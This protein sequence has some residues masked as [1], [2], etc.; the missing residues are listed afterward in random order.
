MRSASSG[1]GG[2]SWTVPAE[3][4]T[5][6]AV[7]VVVVVIVSWGSGQS[8]TGRNATNA[9][10]AFRP[11]MLMYPSSSD[12]CPAKWKIQ[13]SSFV[14]RAFTTTTT[15][16]QGRTGPWR[17]ITSFSFSSRRFFN[18]FSKEGRGAED[19]LIRS[20]R[21]RSPV[22]PR[23]DNLK[24]VSFNKVPLIIMPGWRPVRGERELDC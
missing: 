21:R 13:S 14:R 4:T 6:P 9:I 17:G 24:L 8:G 12:W 22:A 11:F 23:T 19:S 1:G 3:D 10:F 20:G 18:K 7:V 5:T 15:T 2:N 16:R